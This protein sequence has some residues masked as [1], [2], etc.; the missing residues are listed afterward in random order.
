MAFFVLMFLNLLTFTRK[1]KLK[2]KIYRI[3][4]TII[5]IKTYTTRRDF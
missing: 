2:I 3:K 1:I 5:I 4:S